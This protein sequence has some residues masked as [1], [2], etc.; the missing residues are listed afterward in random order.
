MEATPGQVI[1]ALQTKGGHCLVSG[2]SPHPLVT[3]LRGSKQCVAWQSFKGHRKGQAVAALQSRPHAQ[4]S[5][6]PSPHPLVSQT[7]QGPCGFSAGTGHFPRCLPGCAGRG[8]SDLT[9]AAHSNAAFPGF[10]TH[11]QEGRAAP[12]SLQAGS[13]SLREEPVLRGLMGTPQHSELTTPTPRPSASSSEHLSL[14]TARPHHA[15]L[16]TLADGTYHRA[17][18]RGAEPDA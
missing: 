18:S 4:P 11:P 5:A 6:A 9:V 7:Q 8:A 16:W 1:T 2:A 17:P 15:P 13:C 3:H 12:A 10:L 14:A